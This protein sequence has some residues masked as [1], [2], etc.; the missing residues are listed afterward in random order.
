MTAL[1][2][3]VFHEILARGFR[4]YPRGIFNGFLFSGLTL[5][6]VW[7]RLPLE[8]LAAWL[9][10]S[11]AVGLYRLS[12][13]RG[14]LRT[15]PAADLEGWARKAAIGYGG[16]G[17]I[18]GTMGAAC[19]HFAPDAR[20]YIM[21]IGFLIVLFA[22]LNA[23]GSAAHPPV[24]R[25]FVLC[26]M[27]PI[28][29]VSAVEPAP[30]AVVRILLEVLLLMVSLAVGHSG[31]RYVAESVA[32]RFENLE[33]LEDLRRQKA[34][35]DEAN[36]AKTHFLAAASHDL[37]QPMQAIVLLVES[38]QDRVAEPG[39]RR[40]V[41]SIRS[42]VTSMAALLNAILDLSRFD[43]GTVR[44]ERAH[45]RVATVLER[46]H[47]T[48]ARQAEERGLRLRVMA[49]SAVVETDPIL[50]FRIL[51]NMTDNALRYTQ[52]GK[53]LVGCRRRGES[54]AI[55]VWD[56]G[57]GIPE[58]EQKEIFREFYQLENP[59]RDREQGLG[60]GL[61]IV[62]RTARLLGHPLEVRSKVGRGTMFSIAV[63]RGDPSRVHAEKARP[64]DWAPL[65]GCRVLVVEDEREIRA[66]MTILLESWGCAVTSAADGAEARAVLVREGAPP[67]VVLADYRLPGDDNGIGVIE[68]VRAMHPQAAG[69]LIS[70]EVAQE[71][72]A[73]AEEAGLRILHKP[74]R[75]ARLRSLLGS[76]WR[77]REPAAE[78][79]E[80]P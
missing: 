50:L 74:L 38:L 39:T 28:L 34:E 29:A 4:A 26:A 2:Q 20:E 51:A 66:A 52:R 16:T 44:P 69:V 61:A 5:V 31:N 80:L 25:A 41:E 18:W 9:A 43:A 8:F 21:V 17:L 7:P 24:F 49:S 1:P 73:K 15:Q 6:L 75:P 72:L 56:S 30:H 13:A 68:A 58:D 27:L 67:D 37:R 59:Q 57:P 14:F 35:L 48:Y 55:E 22:V 78:T 47:N 77:E 76:L 65:H 11:V 70:G 32:L 45:F 23:Q 60:L 53:V 79:A 42:S 36:A 64:P 63:P 10:A 12:L 40:I 71:A 46:L 33:L 62:E 54:I 3:P 19:I